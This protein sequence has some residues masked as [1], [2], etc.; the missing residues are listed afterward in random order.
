MFWFVVLS[1]TTFCPFL[2]ALFYY[3][4]WRNEDNK[5][6]H[7]KNVLFVTAHPDDECMFFA[8][9]ILQLARCAQVYLLCICTGN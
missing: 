3:Q 2:I 1:F 5:E 9:I 7:G 6:F 4:H 8:P